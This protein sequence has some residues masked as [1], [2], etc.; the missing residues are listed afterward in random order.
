MPKCLPSLDEIVDAQKVLYALVPPTPQIS[1]PLLNR[2]LG[3]T[4][5]VKHENH[6]PI[7][8]FKART[9]VIYADELFRKERGVKGLITATRGN[10]GQ[11]V[12]LAGQRFGVPVT[13][14][15][16][17]GNSHEKNT[18]MQAQGA[19]LIEFGGD[20]QA[21]REHAQE[22]AREQSL[23][24]IPPYHRD[25]VKGV[26]TYWIELFTAVPDLD[27]AYVPIG[28]GSGICAGCAVRNGLKLK[29]KIVGVVAE[30]APAYA[31]SFEAGR[32]IEAPVT[33]T[34]ADGMACRLPD[35]EPLAIIRENVD[36]I[37]RVSDA[38]IRS[39]MRIYFSAT[40]NTVE[41]AGA[42]SL[43]AALKEKN[44]IQGKRL[45]VILTGGNVDREVFA[46]VLAEP[47]QTADD[48]AAGQG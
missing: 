25:I 22:L 16:P 23:H 43:A 36:H 17:H 32:K 28:M 18:A 6:T 47:D 40:H 30:G 41:G 14:V 2:R 46:N 8:A 4:A 29:T 26:A 42:A 13:I 45:G 39:A 19:R 48:V 27:W 3:A 21:A 37:V 34:I 24:F 11:S 12:A 38:E 35:E 33:T 31:L 20:F 10:H 1:W 44:S 9:A 15:V 7:G 5:W